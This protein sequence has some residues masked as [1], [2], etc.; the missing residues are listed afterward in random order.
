MPGPPDAPTDARAPLNR[1][2]V[3]RTAVDLADAAGIGSLSMRRLAKELGVEAMSLYHHVADKSD[4]LDAIVDLVVAE[5]WVPSPGDE[6]RSAMRRRAISARDAFIRHPWALGL[7]EASREPGLDR[8][9]YLESVLACLRAAGFPIALAGHAFSTL[10][11]YIYGFVLQERSLTF[12]APDGLV[13][14]GE[15]ILSDMPTGEFPSLQEIIIEF[16]RTGAGFAEE[17]E[18]GLELILDGLERAHLEGQA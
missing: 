12:D 8:L 9:R 11:S 17:F 4:L 16:S 5:I 1:E 13:D 18:F 7:I 15:A 2:R 6:W 10:D 3:L 14:T